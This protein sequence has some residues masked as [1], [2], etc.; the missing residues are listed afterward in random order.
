MKAV[1]DSQAILAHLQR[2]APDRVN[3]SP[4]LFVPTATL[5]ELGL[6]S[7]QF[8]ELVFVIEEEFGVKIDLDNLHVKTVQDVIDIVV[9]RIAATP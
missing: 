1:P 3:V 6:D 8:I 4:E 2:V 5:A 7:F 9:E